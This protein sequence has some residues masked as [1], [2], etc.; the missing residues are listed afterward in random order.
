MGTLNCSWHMGKQRC[1]II[2]VHMFVPRHSNH[3]HV[4]TTIIIFSKNDFISLYDRAYLPPQGS[5][6]FVEVKKLLALKLI[7]NSIAK[8][9]Q[10]VM[11][12][13]GSI[14]D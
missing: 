9:Q 1:D 6:S 5:R 12:R 7:C 13:I 8:T 11:D 3:A 14:H 4:I 10:I 2:L